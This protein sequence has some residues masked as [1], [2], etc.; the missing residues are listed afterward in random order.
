MSAHRLFLALWP[1][2][3]MQSE[4]ADAARAV[5]ESAR[6]GREIPRESLHLTLAFLGSVPEASLPTLRE[7]A[8]AAPWKLAA[9]A[10]RVGDGLPAGGAP[11]TGDALRA[12]GGP[13]ADDGLRA[14]SGPRAGDG[15]RAN[16]G[17]R[18]DDELRTAGTAP[19]SL[20]VTLDA[21][22]YWPRS[23]LLC[24]MASRTPGGAAQLAEALR[25]SLVAAGFSPDLKPFRAHVTLARQVRARPAARGMSPVKW[26]FDDFALIESR[27]GPAGSLYSV[28]E[29][30][31]LG[32]A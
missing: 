13:W 20:D 22:D 25:Q 1:T 26:T 19:S 24:A 9:D 21:I 32:R 18:A 28:L 11:Q 27:T 30:W 16:D 17:L 6:G 23:Q 10:R 3:A 15:P 14:G 2:A 8:S 4:L 7:L 5:M 12:S 29:R 31:P